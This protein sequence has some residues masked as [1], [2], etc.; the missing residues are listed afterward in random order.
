MDY[1]SRL[2]TINKQITGA[3]ADYNKVN[4]QANNAY[5]NFNTN[6]NNA[7]NYG[8][9]YSQARDQ[10][11]NTDEINA[12]KS[13]STNARNAV[14][15][16][17]TTI[18]KLPESISQQ[19]GGTGLTEAQRQRALQTQHSNLANTYNMLNTNYQNA[20]ADYNDL[21]N[22][23]MSEVSQVAG[24][25]YASQ[26]DRIGALQ[27]AWGTLLGQSNEAY[28]RILNNRSQLNDVYAQK[29]NDQ[30]AA[31]TLAYQRWAKNQDLAISREQ[32]NAQTNLQKYLKQM[33]IDANNRPQQLTY[34][35]QLALMD[36]QYANQGMYRN[37]QID[38]T[39]GGFIYSARF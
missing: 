9:I 3:S 6:L 4:N 39:N 18:N 7:K 19:Y 28:N 15:Q 29:L 20:S 13:A 17:N 12:A 8:D 38:P 5:N 16:V 25:N 2:G 11:M 32:T 22:R 37:G 14:D 26:Q 23:A 31:A 1:G 36:K 35:Q 21:A 27:S 10:Y 33:E 24:G 34:E 30:Q